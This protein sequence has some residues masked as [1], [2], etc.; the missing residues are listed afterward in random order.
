MLKFEVISTKKQCIHPLWMRHSKAQFIRGLAL[1]AVVSGLLFGSLSSSVFAASKADTPQTSISNVDASHKANTS[2]AHTSEEVP[3]TGWVRDNKGLYYRL[4]DGSKAYSMLI[5]TDKGY[6]YVTDDGYCARG[7]L[8]MPNGK[9]FYFNKD[10]Y[11]MVT[12]KLTDDHKDYWLDENAGLLYDR[13][14]QDSQGNWLHTDDN[15]VLA[16]GWFKTKSG[17]WFYFNQDHTMKTG[18]L[19]D[20]GYTFWLDKKDGLLYNEWVKDSKGNWLRTD[21]NGCLLTG[22]YHAPNG[23]WFYFNKDNYKMVTGKLTDDHKDYW[24]DEN[25]GLLYDRWVQDS[26]GNWLHTDDNGVLATGWFKT[27]SGYWFYFNQDH[28]MKTGILT[29]KGYTFWLDKNDGLLY[30]EWVKDESGNWLHTDK[31]GCLIKGWFYASNGKSF[32][33]N[34]DYT[35]KVGELKQN[36]KI[37]TLDV[38]QGLVGIRAEQEPSKPEVTPNQ[39]PEPS[40]PSGTSVDNSAAYKDGAFAFFKAKGAARA[41][42]ILNKATYA[43]YTH[44]GNP[45]DASAIKNM[46]AS[47]PEMKKCNELRARHGLKPLRVT[48]ELVAMAMSDANWSSS[49]IAHAQQFNIGENLAWYSEKPFTGWYDKE[50]ALYEADPVKN[51]DAAGHYLNII[52][53]KYECTGFAIATYANNEYKQPCFGQTFLWETH[54]SKSMTVDEYEREL[55]QWVKSIQA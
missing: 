12:G 21:G 29:D 44:K 25:A 30:N 17:Y 48:Y 5:K 34:D 33:F 53:Q 27:K 51:K 55:K 20:R 54:D 26:Q 1:S 52:D 9:W 15:G 23:K 47:I 38:N 49:H 46:L 32:Y 6:R 10:S 41:L 16:T 37:Y 28:T 45:N 2:T 50:K 39:T 31:W 19:T 11:Q 35:M 36:G 14:V 42:E 43:T 8:W 13:W 7:W 3:Q 4:E 22:W 24:L 40:T 18:I